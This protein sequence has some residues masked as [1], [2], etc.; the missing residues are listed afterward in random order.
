MEMLHILMSLN[1]SCISVD[2]D[3]HEKQK[4]RG[5]ENLG[6]IAFPVSTTHTMT[7]GL[8][9]RSRQQN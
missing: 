5:E 4:N 3:R 9:Q 7:S 8:C 2:E 6:G 1:C